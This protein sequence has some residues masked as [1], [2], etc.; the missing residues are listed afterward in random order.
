MKRTLIAG[1]AA[2]A[3]AGCSQSSEAKDASPV[4]GTQ[5]QEYDSGLVLAYEEDAY[6]VYTRVNSNHERLSLSIHV[7]DNRQVIEKEPHSLTLNIYGNEQKNC[8]KRELVDVTMWGIANAS[9]VSVREDW[10]EGTNNWS[11]F[12]FGSPNY[13]V[14]YTLIDEECDE[15]LDKMILKD[16]PNQE[17]TEHT[18]E[19]MKTDDWD[20]LARWERVLNEGA[21]II[22]N[23]L[24]T[25]VQLE[26]WRERGY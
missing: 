8:K 20:S 25:D 15:K 4:A 9:G 1:L 14:T 12:I 5:A 19:Q 11:E 16:G 21:T 26:A 13:Y 17:T 2:I 22:D 23:A 3:L 18:R 24:D 6:G 10:R 7:M